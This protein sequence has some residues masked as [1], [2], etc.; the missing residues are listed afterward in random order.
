[1]GGTQFTVYLRNYFFRKIQE[2]YNSLFYFYFTDT[3]SWNYLNLK[4]FYK[5]IQYSLSNNLIRVCLNHW[6]T[7]FC[8]YIPGS[9]VSLMRCMG[10]L[11][12]FSD[13]HIVSSER[14]SNFFFLFSSPTQGRVQWLTASS[15]GL[16][17]TG[18]AIPDSIPPKPNLGERIRK[19]LSTRI[20]LR[21]TC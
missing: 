4:Y 6:N 3:S 15:I 12:H 21:V 11:K 20:A 7:S 9:L 17:Y 2:I 16:R 1:M 19:Y 13:T 18:P 14:C 8:W 10:L 5:S